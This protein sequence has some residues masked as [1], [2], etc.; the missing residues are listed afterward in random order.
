MT[1]QE[2]RE[3]NYNS[4]S[5]LKDFSVDRR[6]YHKKYILKEEVKEKENVAVNMGRLVETLLMEPER[7]DDMFFMSTCV[8]IP[9]GMLGDFIQ[10]LAQ[11]VSENT[12]EEGE[13]KG[14]FT[15]Y[16][17]EAYKEAGF[18]IKFDTVLKKLEDPENEIYYQ[19]CLNVYYY[20]MTLVTAQD[21]ENAEKIVEELRNNPTTSTIVTLTDTKDFS[22]VNQMKLEDFSVDKLR[23]KAMLDKVI[24]D[25]KNQV[26]KPFDLKCT[27]SVENFYKEYYLYR[28]AYIQAYVY[29]RGLQYF[30]NN[31]PDCEFYGYEVEHPQF[32]VCDS[33]NYYQP[34]IYVLDD[35]DMKDAYEGFEHNGKYY[36][37]V[38]DIIAELKWAIKEDIWTISKTNFDKKGVL[39][40]KE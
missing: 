10:K 26:V 11:L 1:E 23:M 17:E 3:L 9:G 18:K 28:R 34:L 27:W 6:K 15:D 25:H 4:S 30:A 8:K 39:N 7:F 16:A 24:I 19:E 32:I 35:D 38:K 22:V 31:D 29:W 37:G 36:P 5:S 33:I 21:V 2:Y 14:E 40:I 20:K 13:M 12:S